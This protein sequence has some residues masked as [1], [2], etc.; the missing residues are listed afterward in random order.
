[1]TMRCQH[2]GKVPEKTYCEVASWRYELSCWGMCL[3]HL[4]WC[5]GYTT[6]DVFIC[7]TLD[8][9]IFSYLLFKPLY[10]IHCVLFFVMTLACSVSSIECLSTV[11]LVTK[12][13]L[14]SGRSERRVPR[15]SAEGEE[16]VDSQ[17]VFMKILRHTCH[18]GTTQKP[19][20]A[21]ENCFD[22][23][24]SQSAMERCVLFKC[25]PFKGVYGEQSRDLHPAWANTWVSMSCFQCNR[26]PFLVQRNSFEAWSWRRS[27]LVLVQGMVGSQESWAYFRTKDFNCSCLTEEVQSHDTSF[28]IT[29]MVLEVEIWLYL[30]PDSFLAG[31]YWTAPIYTPT[32]C[33]GY[34]RGSSLSLLEDGARQ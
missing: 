9:C 5:F 29:S 12:G 22:G 17:W 1:M 15:E 6:N 18:H 24:R 30:C 23:N 10:V 4:C 2:R 16:F 13:W 3:G 20:W 7:C 14:L 28:R 8:F 31:S 25:G 26:V 34:G 27:F 32:H 21:Y 11:A 19:E 33:E